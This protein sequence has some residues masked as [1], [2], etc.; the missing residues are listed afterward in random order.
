MADKKPQS[1]FLDID[2]FNRPVV[3]AL[4]LLLVCVI[5]SGCYRGSLS[6]KP[7]IHPNQNMDSQQKYK[8]Q[9]ESRFFADRSTMRIPPAGTVAR[10]QLHEDSAFFR[11][12]DNQGKPLEN[13]PMPITLDL[14]HRGRQR[15]DIYCS[16]CH[17]RL[18]DGRGMVVRRGYPPPP[19][20]TDDR[21][22][23]VSDGHIF[24][25]ITEGLRNMPA[26]KYQIPPADRWA[27]VA[28]LRALQRS[29][30]A[31]YTDL[32]DSVKGILK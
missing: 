14:M 30:S 25:V 21:L 19:A 16:A 2:R 26:Y 28:Y 5:V 24:R 1:R 31:R 9:A 18:G 20:F 7:P 15:Y 10:G 22:L 17:G 23:G 29:Q 8:A 27:I 4:S 11:G 6:D 32:P 12:V 13:L 3:L